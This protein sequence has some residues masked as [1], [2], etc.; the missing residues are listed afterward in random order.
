MQTQTEN[1]FNFIFFNLLIDLRL[2]IYIM[3]NRRF[4]SLNQFVTLSVLFQRIF[5]MIEQLIGATYILFIREKGLISNCFILLYF[6]YLSDLFSSNTART[7]TG[8]YAELSRKSCDQTVCRIIFCS[9]RAIDKNGS[10]YRTFLMHVAKMVTNSSR[11]T[12]TA[13]GTTENYY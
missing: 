2:I 4:S 13:K 7:S 11:F 5:Y 10:I 8:Q 9:M 1:Y 3:K 6:V 12:A